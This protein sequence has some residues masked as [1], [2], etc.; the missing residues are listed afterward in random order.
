M[1]RTCTIFGS[2][3][4]LGS[5]VY[6]RKRNLTLNAETF[7]T[8]KFISVRTS[9]VDNSNKYIQLGSKFRTNTVTTALEPE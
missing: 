9:K 3:S 7:V 6:L 2:I 8:Q 5:Y 4:T 1:Y